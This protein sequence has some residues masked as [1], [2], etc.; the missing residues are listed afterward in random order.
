[1]CAWGQWPWRRANAYCYAGVG[2]DEMGMGLRRCGGGLGCGMAR[3]GREW[4]GMG[5]NFRGWGW[6]LTSTKGTK[7]AEKSEVGH[8]AYH[9]DTAGGSGIGAW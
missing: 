7:D 6:N 9:R 4:A 2:R 5:R 1:M 8:A 3:V